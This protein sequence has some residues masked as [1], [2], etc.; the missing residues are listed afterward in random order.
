MPRFLVEYR[1]S[2]T[3]TNFIDA[4]T[5]EEAD[6]KAYAFSGG[7]DDFSE[8]MGE[9]DEVTDVDYSVRQ[10]SRVRREDGSIAYTTYVR[11]TDTVLPD[12][13]VVE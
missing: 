10:M 2:G 4:E 1:V 7:D 9:I 5:E 13:E 11:K 3:I 12:E 6:A 8:A